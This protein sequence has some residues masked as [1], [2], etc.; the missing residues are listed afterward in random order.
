MGLG[1]RFRRLTRL[2][3]RPVHIA[4]AHILTA[5]AY[6]IRGGVETRELM[7]GGEGR[8][9]QWSTGEEGADPNTHRRM[10]VH[11]FKAIG[12]LCLEGNAYLTA[13]PSISVSGFGDEAI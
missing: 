3:C 11:S 8:P 9:R 12:D 5:E 4:P 1:G 10:Q 13:A 6:H 2:A 7:K